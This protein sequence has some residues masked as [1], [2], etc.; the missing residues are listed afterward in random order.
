MFL[1]IIQSQCT[2]L[3]LIWILKNFLYIINACNAICSYF[4]SH[5]FFSFIYHSSFLGF[6]INIL[7][8]IPN[9][10]TKLEFWFLKYC[11][12]LWILKYLIIHIFYIFS[13]INFYLCYHPNIIGFTSDNLFYVSNAISKPKLSRIHHKCFQ[14]Y[15]SI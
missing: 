8:Y 6:T 15:P 4:Q 3:W 7:W 9:R 11:I 12:F 14:V 5:C 1:T 13:K 10:A 2:N